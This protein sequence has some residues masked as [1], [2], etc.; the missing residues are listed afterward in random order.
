[1]RGNGRELVFT[2]QPLHLCT[3]TLSWSFGAHDLNHMRQRHSR[4]INPD[5]LSAIFACLS[6]LYNLCAFKKWE[7]RPDSLKGFVGYRGITAHSLLPWE[8]MNLW[9]SWEFCFMLFFGF[10]WCGSFIMGQGF[11][12]TL[13]LYVIVYVTACVVSHFASS[14]GSTGHR[15]VTGW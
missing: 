11:E 12:E 15:S 5:S 9:V 3:W 10:F 8:R 6:S 4:A 2:E 14:S 7:K 1:M 13:W